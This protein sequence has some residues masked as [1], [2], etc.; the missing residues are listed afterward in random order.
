MIIMSY[1]RPKR[2]AAAHRPRRLLA[3]D[4]A[5]ISG[6]LFAALLIPGPVMTGGSPGTSASAAQVQSWYLAHQSLVG[7][8]TLVLVLAVIVGL[9]FLNYVRS[10]FRRYEGGWMTSLFWAG[11][12]IWAVSGVLGAGIHAA[13]SDDP[14][15]LSPDSLQ[16]LNALGPNIG[17]PAT[18]IGLAVMFLGA[19]LVITSRQPRTCRGRRRQDLDAGVAVPAALRRRRARGKCPR[20]ADAADHSQ[21]RRG[22]ENPTLDGHDSSLLGT[23]GVGSGPDWCRRDHGPAARRLWPPGKTLASALVAAL[24]SGFRPWPSRSLGTSRSGRAYG[25][26]I[27]PNRTRSPRNRVAWPSRV[28]L[29]IALWRPGPDPFARM[30]RP[31]CERPVLA[32][33]DVLNSG[34]SRKKLPSYRRVRSPGNLATSNY[35]LRTSRSVWRPGRVQLAPNS[36]R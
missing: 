33:R 28:V 20:R 17:Y 29:P 31:S 25:V 16:L 14:K 3:P 10:C 23:P 18:C 34:Q 1:V 13:I 24:V 4:R 36:S 35:S 5:A 7:A 11:A 12:I 15:V 19:D 27:R 30:R 32:K 26:P 2:V 21:R 22:G 9:F 8:S 6:I